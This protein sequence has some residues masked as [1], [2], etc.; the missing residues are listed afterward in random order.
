MIQLLMSF[1]K[2]PGISISLVW[3]EHHRGFFNPLQKR[4][5]SFVHSTEQDPEEIAGLAPFVVRNFKMITYTAARKR[6]KELVKIPMEF[7]AS[8]FKPW[9]H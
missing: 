4:F 9:I 7:E 6:F 2:Q 5:Y 3:K 1:E 8:A